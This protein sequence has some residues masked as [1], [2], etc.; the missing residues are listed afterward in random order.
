MREEGA[1]TLVEKAGREITRPNIGRFFLRVRVRR[2]NGGDNAKCFDWLRQDQATK[3][4]EEGNAHIQKQN[5]EQ[6]IESYS[7]AIEAEPTNHI[8]YSN[9]SLAY[10]KRCLWKE[11]L[12]DAQKSV[13]LNPNWVKVV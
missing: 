3:L 5:Y 12:C 6:A 9:R 7:K 2:Q 1:R 8:L 11:G 13:E 10:N 4:K